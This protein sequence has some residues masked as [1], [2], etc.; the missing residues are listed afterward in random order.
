MMSISVD[1]SLAGEEANHARLFGFIR[2][3]LLEKGYSYHSEAMPPILMEM[4]WQHMQDSRFN[5]AGIGRHQDHVV[6]HGVRSDEIC[7][8]AGNSAAG[9]A[10]LV[11]AEGLQTYLNRQLMLG[12]FSF[13]SHF[14]H[15]PACGFYKKHKDAFKGEANRILSVVVYLN[16]DWQQGDAGELVLYDET[17]S[18]N[19]LSVPPIFGS[20]IVFLS[21]DFPHEVLPTTKD[22]HS[23]AGWFR[24][25]NFNPVA[26]G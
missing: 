18:E 7:W 19:I 21:E 17:G 8:I 4:L 13:E 12:L 14:A 23:I 5:V 10:W 15:F 16:K 26:T 11:W 1:T 25:N 3:N 9:K 20:V 22:R 2:N 6:N 24:L